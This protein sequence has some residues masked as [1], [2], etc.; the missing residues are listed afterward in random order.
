MTS[1]KADFRKQLNTL[2]AIF[3][4]ANNV[5]AIKH[6]VIQGNTGGLSYHE[7]NTCFDT[8][9]ADGHIQLVYPVDGWKELKVADITGQGRI[10]F[11]Q[12]GYKDQRNQVDKTM[13][14]FKNHKLF[15]KLII[16]AI[17]FTAVWGVVEIVFK[18]IELFTKQ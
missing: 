11:E 2:L 17:I 16:A 6:L 8:L 9:L 13:D 15:S 1:T 14:W 10:F 3:Y 7:L 5:V 4:N 12:G 18:I